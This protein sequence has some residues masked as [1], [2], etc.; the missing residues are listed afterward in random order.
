MGSDIERLL[1]D[2]DATAIAAAIRSGEVDAGDVVATSI[3]RAEERNPALNAFVTTR[4]DRAAA[5]SSSVDREAPFAGVPFVVKD[6]GAEVAGLPQ[7]RG[8]RLFADDVSYADSELVRR[9]RSA[10][11]IILGTTNTPE[12]GL[13]AS[14]EP[15][16]NGPTRNPHGLDHSAGGSSGGTAAAV[17][18]G[19]VP[20][21]HGN[22]GGGSIRIPSSA[23]GLFGLKPSRGRVSAHPAAT[24]LA[25]PM[26][27]H[28]VLTR[29]V[30]D[31]AALLDLTAGS[32]PGDPYEIAGPSRPWVDDVGADPGTLRI[33][34][35]LKA[36][37][38]AVAHPECVA[39]VE[40][41]AAVLHELGHEVVEADPPWSVEVLVAVMSAL[42]GTPMA[43]QI[44]ARL[45][46][47]GR[48]LADDDLEPFTRF[49]YDAAAATTG[50]EVVEAL[51][52]L[53]ELARSMGDFLTGYDLVLTPTLAQ[54]TPPLGYLDT[55]SIEAMFER[56]ATYSAFTSPFNI[57]G[58]PAASLPLTIGSNGMPIGV[59][60]AA[61]FGREDRLIAVSSQ[62]EAAHPWPVVP[63]WPARSE[64]GWTDYVESL[65]H[66]TVRTGAGRR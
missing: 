19:I 15:A 48:D 31:S 24:L 26:G 45:A 10:G 17:A 2:H 59:Q 4:F 6:L 13:N 53:E 9:Y 28:H 49:L 35:V 21:G 64:A 8:S 51:V 14:T 66:T 40:S 23:C 54:P 61:P 41:A 62:D 20:L 18:A 11:L 37:G 47:L 33:A 46:E 22:D 56:A 42:M 5:E 63:A 3:A 1:D 7:T 34:M 57:T 44:D 25:D 12:L 30:R 55:T 38:G 50:K 39:A 60:L 16:L 27:C 43:V 36:P 29:S 65:A 58:Q 32:M 52:A